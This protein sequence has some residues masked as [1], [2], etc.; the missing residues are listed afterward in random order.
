VLAMEGDFLSFL[1]VYWGDE[2]GDLNEGDF[3]A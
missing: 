2:T 3:V 1:G